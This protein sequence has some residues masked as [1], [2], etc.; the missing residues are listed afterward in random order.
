VTFQTRQDSPIRYGLDVSSGLGPIDVYAEAA[1]TK[2]QSR[3]FYEGDLDP[4]AGSLPTVTDREDDTFTQ[5]VAGVQ[6]SL[7]YND[8]DSVNVGAEY[9]DNGLGYDDRTLQLYSLIMG[10]SSPLYAGRRYAGAFLRA[11]TPGSWNE[12]SFFVNALRN[13]S[14]QSTVARLTATWLVH[15]DA[16]F[17]A[18]VSQCFGDYGEFCF[19]IPDKFVALAA[20][21]ALTPEQKQTLLGL[22]TKRTKT[23]AG[24]AMSMAF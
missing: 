5:G 18:F 4:V 20:S 11:P 15:K 19:R 24:V 1:L 2:R 23:T 8:D 9:F 10:E 22:P 12:T 14:D 3:D 6:Y 16:T 13:L 17:E 7:K 21:P